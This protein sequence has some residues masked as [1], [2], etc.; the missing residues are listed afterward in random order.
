[1]L[2]SFVVLPSIC[3]LS[4]TWV[5][6]SNSLH[7]ANRSSPG[8][9]IVKARASGMASLRGPCWRRSIT[10]TLASWSPL[11][12]LAA[13][14][15]GTGR[16]ETT[17][18]RRQGQGARFGSRGEAVALG[19][20]EHPGPENGQSKIELSELVAYVQAKVETMSIVG[21]DCSLTPSLSV[22]LL[23]AG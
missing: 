22:G 10:A 18:P 16:A 20:H 23:R 6:S 4:Q 14:Y 13:K 3:L 7:S 8:R 5:S 21:R 12:E 1:M 15:G 11:P 9:T 2:C 17:T 19:R